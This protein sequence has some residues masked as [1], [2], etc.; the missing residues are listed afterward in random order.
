MDKRRHVDTISQANFE[1]AMAG[2]CIVP[3]ISGVLGGFNLRTG[4]H[5]R[6][7]VSVEETDGEGCLIHDDEAESGRVVG[8]SDEQGVG[9][10][11]IAK[12]GRDWADHSGS[13]IREVRRAAGVVSQFI[14][15]VKSERG[16]EGEGTE[17]DRISFTR[18]ELALA[19]YSYLMDKPVVLWGTFDLTDKAS[20][21]KGA[22]WLMREVLAL[23]DHIND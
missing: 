1:I 20:V 2:D 4:R 19:C 9:D 11:F 5:Y 16:G 15:P 23:N 10:S 12:L 22:E 21:K 14:R 18:E 8:E 3:A 13:D 6:V 17:D 7:S